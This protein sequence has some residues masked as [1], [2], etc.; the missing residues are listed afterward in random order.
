[1]TNEEAREK[2]LD[3]YPDP[4]WTDHYEQESEKYDEAIKNATKALLIV[5]LIDKTFKRNSDLMMDYDDWLL[6]LSALEE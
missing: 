1:M 2:L 3:G 5:D 4:V 6:I